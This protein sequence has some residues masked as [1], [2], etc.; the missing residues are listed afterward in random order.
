M[1]QEIYA[2]F[3]RSAVSDWAS[4]CSSNTVD[5]YSGGVQVKSWPRYWLSWLVFCGFMQVMW[6]DTGLYLDRTRFLQDPFPLYH[7]PPPT[8]LWFYV[9]STDTV[10]KWTAK[11]RYYL[12]YQYYYS[13]TNWQY[14]TSGREPF[15][16]SKL[17]GV[18]HNSVRSKLHKN[19]CKIPFFLKALFL[20]NSAVSCK[21]YVALV[22]DGWVNECVTGGMNPTWDSQSTLRKI[23][24]CHLVQHRSHVDWPGVET[25]LLRWRAGDWPQEPWHSPYLC[26]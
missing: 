3:Q 13:S 9:G 25:G 7:S 20:C 17:E 24:H 2:V 14:C 16:K 18:W 10:V 23:L 22:R 5:F 11:K 19:W 15:I 4:W 26:P 6:A 8:I 1:V 21:G 12:E